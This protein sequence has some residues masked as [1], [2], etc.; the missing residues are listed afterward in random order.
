MIV[1]SQRSLNL[2]LDVWLGTP[3]RVTFIYIPHSTEVASKTRTSRFVVI[4]GKLFSHTRKRRGWM[5]W[6]TG[7]WCTGRTKHK[8]CFQDGSVRQANRTCLNVAA[9]ARHH[10]SLSRQQNRV[11]LMQHLSLKPD[12]VLLYWSQFWP[13]DG[14]RWKNCE[15]EGDEDVE[16]CH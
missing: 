14:I 15:C 11:Q 2:P 8:N 9:T 13:N 1:S 4:K 6:R 10:I 3:R 7:P 16:K 5:N 12:A